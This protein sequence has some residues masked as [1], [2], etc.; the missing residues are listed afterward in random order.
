MD[1]QNFLDVIKTRR[2]VRRFSN[3]PIPS[4]IMNQILD[5]GLIA[6]NSSNLQPWEFY[7]IR[8]ASTREKINTAF[9]DQPA[10]KTAAEVVVAVARI[11]TWRRH[12]REMAD[13]LKNSNPPAPQMAIDYYTKIVPLAYEVGWLGLLGPLKGFLFWAIGFF[14]PVPRECTSL[15]HLKIWAVKSTA[16][17]SENIMLAARAFGFDSCPMEG[18]DSSRVRSALKLPRDAVVVMGI[19]LGE[20][21]AEGVYGPQIRFPRERFIKES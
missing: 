13:T 1:T 18:M 14:R 19:A 10:V 15:S 16:L 20:R 2:S 9:L 8:N 3:K 12:A 21:S 6:P 7:W 17:A 5:C 4:E 11:G